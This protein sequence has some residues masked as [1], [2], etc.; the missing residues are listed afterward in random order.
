MQRLI[1]HIGTHKT[2]TTSFQRTLREHASQLHRRDGIQQI[3]L[4]NGYPVQDFMRLT[5]VDRSLTDGLRRFLGQQIGRRRGTTVISCEYLSGDRAAMYANRACIAEMLGEATK[6]YTTEVCVFFRRQDEFIQSMYAQR[7][8]RGEPVDDDVEEF[9][10]S[11]DLD[12]LDWNR[13]LEPY[14][15]TFG[16]SS[17]RV[18][19]YDRKVFE[20]HTVTELLNRVIRSAVLAELSEERS[21]NTGYTPSSI[22]IADRLNRELNGRQREILRGALQTVGSKGM[23]R[24]YNLLS[25]ETKQTLVDRFQPANRRLAARHFARDFGIEDFSGPVFE[26]ADA[27][28]EEQFYRLTKHLLAQIESEAYLD[29]NRVVRT[30]KAVTRLLRRS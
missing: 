18:F 29:A 19:P 4:Q 24:E 8:H 1:L 27:G 23:L 2:G 30:L 10:R 6:R 7:V 16:E 15:D 13:F 11:L 17:V 21:D 28:I 20:D 5:E 14:V 12:L 26:E 25:R 22:E 9:V 3:W